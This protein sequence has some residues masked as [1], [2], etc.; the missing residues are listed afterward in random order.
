MA[1]VDVLAGMFPD[2]LQ[3]FVLSINET[4]IAIIKQIGSNISAEDLEKLRTKL[5]TALPDYDHIWEGDIDC[6]L[7]S[8]IGDGVLGAAVQVLD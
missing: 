1:T 5:M 8:Y 4:D 6:T 2:K 7:S 3:D